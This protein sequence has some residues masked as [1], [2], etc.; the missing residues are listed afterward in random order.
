MKQITF[1]FITVSREKKRT[2]KDLND[3]RRPL[4]GYEVISQKNYLTSLYSLTILE[5]KKKTV[6]FSIYPLDAVGLSQIM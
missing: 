3:F 2:Y 4:G 5:Y 6:S 1:K